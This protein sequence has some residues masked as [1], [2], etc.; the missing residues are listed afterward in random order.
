MATQRW[1]GRWEQHT[2]R[3]MGKKESCLGADQEVALSRYV[4]EAL[5]SRLFL[6]TTFASL[7]Y[8]DPFPAPSQLGQ[9]SQP[10]GDVLYSDSFTDQTSTSNGVLGPSDHY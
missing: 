1:D 7:S 10:A 5:E 6:A 2:K 4:V 3:R 8:T 9:P